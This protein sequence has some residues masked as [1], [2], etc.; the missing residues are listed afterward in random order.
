M[1]NSGT[2]IGRGPLPMHLSFFDAN[3]LEFLRTKKL[4]C[5]GSEWAA[6]LSRAP[7]L[8][9]VEFFFQWDSQA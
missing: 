9:Y 2:L 6:A 4:K 5:I 8:T 1:Y 3:A 7:A